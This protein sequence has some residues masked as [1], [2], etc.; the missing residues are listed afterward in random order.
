[1]HGTA[2]LAEH[3]PTLIVWGKD[4]AV[5]PVEHGYPALEEAM[6]GSRLEIFEEAG[7]LPQLDDPKRF[8][9]VVQDFVT[10][11]DPSA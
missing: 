4:D 8:V 5:L 6:P 2:D 11:T 3:M 7:H 1:M 9:H 10:T